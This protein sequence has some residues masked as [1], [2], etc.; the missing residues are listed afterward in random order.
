MRPPRTLAQATAP[1]GRDLVAV[2][3]ALARTAAA[4]S[5]V[6]NRNQLAEAGITPAQIK[7]AVAA[8]RWRSFGRHVVVLHNASLSPPQQLWV[9]VLLPGKRCALAG[10][11]AASLAGLRGFE[12]VEVHVV[13]RHATHT[14]MPGWVRI[15]ESHRFSDDDID[16]GHGPP[17]TRTA[18]SVI[19]AATW[20]RPPRRA[21]AILCAA[22]Q[23]RITTVDRLADE[24]ARAGPVRHVRAMRS[25]LGD[26]AGGGHTLAEI[27]VGPLAREA[28]LPPPSRQAYRREADGRVR[29]LD[30]EFA[31]P[32][33]QVLVVEIDGRHHMYVEAWREDADRQNELVID[34]RPVLRFPSLTVRL[35]PHRVVDQLRR[36]RLAHTP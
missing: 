1:A 19:D 15:H 6:L 32:D 10:P 4:Q 25:I 34:G 12:T 17:R 27:D 16:E 5:G 20:S 35:E 29:W 26:I 28:G 14:A 7:S 3:P 9:A 30:V 2:S 18:R 31:L 22:V 24:L 36:M 33:G 8:R 21:C 11:S 23:Q 13:V